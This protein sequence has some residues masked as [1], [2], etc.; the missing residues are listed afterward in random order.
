MKKRLYFIL[1]INQICRDT[2]TLLFD[3]NKSKRKNNKEP[4][5]RNTD[6]LALLFNT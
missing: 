5:H 2:S 3:S 6:R 4:I 1:T